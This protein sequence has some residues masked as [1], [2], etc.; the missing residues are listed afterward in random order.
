MKKIKLQALI[1]AA[2]FAAFALILDLLPSI[3]LG[4]W[5]SVSC[6]M[7]PIFILA[8]RWGFTVS[9]ISGF[10]WGLLQVATGDAYILN[11]VQF[12]IE[13]FVAFAF[14][15]FAG[16]LYKQIQTAFFAE[17]KKAKGLILAVL[18]VFLGSIA[19]YFWHFLAGVVF[20]A[21][22]APEGMSPVI[23]S[24]VVNGATM[25]GAAIFC[26]ILIVLLLSAAPRLIQRKGFDIETNKTTTS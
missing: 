26:S 6:A 10:I 17:K 7:L 14:V 8:F 4:P 11:I 18:A 12:L 16:L 21:E 5:M 23:Y 9:V 19:R 22:Y 25:I 20:W 2:F 3:Q 13:Y 1:E 24:L 15:G